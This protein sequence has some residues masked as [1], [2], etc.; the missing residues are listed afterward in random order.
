MKL[1][2]RAA[3][4]LLLVSGSLCP[5]FAQEPNAKVT[6]PISDEIDRL[7]W[8]RGREILHPA[9][10]LDLKGVEEEG[11]DFRHRT[12]LLE[13]SDR[14]G[15]QVDEEENHLRRL[16]MYAEGRSFHA[17]LVTA[18]GHAG[19]A[20]EARSSPARFANSTPD[21]PDESTGGS[22]WLLLLLLPGT[23]ALFLAGLVWARYR[24]LLAGVQW[25]SRSK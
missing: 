15:A 17:P 16:A 10:P 20:P 25:P 2:R 14:A 22:S 23:L 8:D 12:P 9:D 5:A 3:G 19:T 24:G 7:L 6:E 21:G 13:Q 11:N 18:T 1:L 4:C